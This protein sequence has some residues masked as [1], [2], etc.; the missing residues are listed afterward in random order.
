MYDYGIDGV[1][2][3]VGVCEKRA[4][5][6]TYPLK[7]PKNKKGLKEINYEVQNQQCLPEY[8]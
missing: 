7:F 5:D 6:P 1:S 4:E 3:G 8:Q 2:P